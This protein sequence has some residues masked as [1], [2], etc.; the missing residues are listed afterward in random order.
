M[1][2]KESGRER[3]REIGAAEV[4]HFTTT[5]GIILPPPSLHGVGCDTH[6]RQNVRTI[7]RVRRPKCS[8]NL[9]G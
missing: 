6:G 1:W 2:R 9:N 5:A 7:R 3:D 8:I 4:V